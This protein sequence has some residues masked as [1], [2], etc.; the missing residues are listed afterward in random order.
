MRNLVIARTA[1]LTILGLRFKLPLTDD[2]PSHS[3]T[4]KMG[5]M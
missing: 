5:L 4:S 2:R 3:K 1:E